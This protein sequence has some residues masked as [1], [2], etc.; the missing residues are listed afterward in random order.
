MRY[1]YSA[2]VTLFGGCYELLKN[3]I[4]THGV[5]LLVLKTRQR[6][7]ATTRKVVCKGQMSAIS[8]LPRWV[9]IRCQLLFRG[10]LF[11]GRDFC[12]SNS[13]TRA[14]TGLQ[15]CAPL[16]GSAKK[17]VDLRMIKPRDR[18]RQAFVADLKRT[19]TP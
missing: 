15:K 5:P 19:V 3:R 16:Y 2:K 7:A 10:Y 8:P 17:Y 1:G 13:T 18:G 9:F 12:L 11:V 4:L 14:N 6:S